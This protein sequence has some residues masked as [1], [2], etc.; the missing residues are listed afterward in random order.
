MIVGKGPLN[1]IRRTLMVSFFS[2]FV[3]LCVFSQENFYFENLGFSSDGKYFL[4]GQYGINVNSKKPVAELYFVNVDKN[5]YYPG[6]VFKKTY[7]QPSEAGEDGKKALYSLL[8]NSEVSLLRQKL[9]INHLLTGRLIYLVHDEEGQ[10]K[11]FSHRDLFFQDLEKGDNYRVTL[12]KNI[13]PDR[14]GRDLESSFFI[15]AQLLDDMGKVKGHLVSGHPHYNRK[16]ISDY[17]I[18]QIYIT[19]SQEGELL[20]VIERKNQK[21]DGSIFYDHM[22]EIGRLQEKK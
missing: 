18:I 4:F 13:N 6:G 5:I 1:M 10:S 15:N 21:I 20:F 19:P 22:I 7:N 17:R 9:K 11:D 3:T 2:V 16:G 12:R 14:K 8:A